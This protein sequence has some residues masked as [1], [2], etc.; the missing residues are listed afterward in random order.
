MG[1]VVKGKQVSV[2]RHN[3]QFWRKLVS[4]EQQLASKL[5]SETANQARGPGLKHAGLEIT[6]TNCDNRATMEEGAKP[7]EESSGAIESLSIKELKAFLEERGVSYADCFEKCELI[8]RAK[9]SQH[10]PTK[11]Q[12][13]Q[14][15]GGNLS[16]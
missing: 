14:H 2:I 3:S 13:K 10:I 5:T 11:K 8:A 9:E 15:E 1:E 7:L 16:V 4:L 6:R 12:P